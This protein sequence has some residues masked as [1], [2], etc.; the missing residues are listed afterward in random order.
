[1]RRGRVLCLPAHGRKRFIVIDYRAV[2]RPAEIASPFILGRYPLFDHRP[3]KHAFVP[4][5]TDSLKLPVV[6]GVCQLSPRNTFS[7]VA[8]QEACVIA[9]LMLYR[10]RWQAFCNQR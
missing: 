4:R 1:M 7:P 8:M 9:H 5:L 3:P 6:V 10:L 2:H